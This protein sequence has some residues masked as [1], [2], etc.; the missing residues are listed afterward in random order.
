MIR[1]GY[2]AVALILTSLVAVTPA[3]AA[4]PP[5]TL[6]TVVSGLNRPTYV[7]HAPGDTTRLFFTEQSTGRVRIIKNGSLMATPFLDVSGQPGWTGMTTLEYGLLS[8]CFHP[9][10]FTNG[11]F[12][13]CFT[14][15][16]PSGGT[17]KLVR[18]QVSAGNPDVANV[19]SATVIQALTY[20]LAQHRSAWM[21]FGPDDGYLYYNTGDGGENDTLNAASDLTVMRGK[22]LRIDV[23]GP[24]G[25]PGTADDDGFPADANKHY[26]IPPTNPFVTT[27][28]AAPEIWAYGFRNPWRASFDR[29]TH[30]IWVGDVGQVTREEIDFI[31]AGVGGRFY[32]WRCKEG[33][34]TTSYTGCTGAL[35]PSIPPVFEYRGGVNSN[36]IGGSSA[37]GGYVYRGCAIPGL[38]G[39]YIFGDW[40]GQVASLRYSDITGELIAQNRTSTLGFSGTLSSFGEDAL[41]EIYLCKWGATDGAILKIVPTTPQGPDCNAN[42]KRDACDIAA[43]TSVDANANG[44]PDECECAT[45]NGDTTGDGMIDALDIQRFA[46][47]AGAAN[48][49]GPGCRCANMNADSS[50]N[51]ADVPIF[52]DKLLGTTDPD[53][54]CP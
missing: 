54:A 52:I 18:F 6:A 15:N 13:V 50:V 12:Y 24:D 11:Y 39:T 44:V 7:T 10:Y 53:P 33:N 49:N 16:V 48:L 4:E 51:I 8:L 47:C 21:D 27:P 43:G 37:I 25:I 31:P 46:G 41:G 3:A 17:A 40:N 23:N 26:H 29:L 14:S 22:M 38:N 32:G 30:D 2:L 45:C 34:F 19:A 1:S 36:I 35:P 28:G 9:Q 5:L 42:G 20:T